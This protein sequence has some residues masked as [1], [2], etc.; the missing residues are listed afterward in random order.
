MRRPMVLVYTSTMHWAG[1]GGHQHNVSSRRLHVTLTERQYL[2]LREESHRTSVSMAEL[3]RRSI[4][5]AL[6]PHRRM[7]FRGLELSLVLARQLDAA[8]AA[9]RVHVKGQT[10]GSRERVVERD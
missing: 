2:L 7:T 3:V 10:G 4:D 1:S 5:T 9:R 8:L 6:R